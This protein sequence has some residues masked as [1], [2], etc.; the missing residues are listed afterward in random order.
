MCATVPSAY[1][2]RVRERAAAL[3]SDGCSGVP[4]FY[5]DCCLQHD[6]AYRTGADVDGGPLTRSQ[7]DAQLRDCIRARS[8]WGPW[9]PMGWWRWAGVRLFGG[10]SWQGRP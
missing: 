1:W 2:E 9:S 7:A 6:I 10:K 4:D 3:Q 5:L 8:P